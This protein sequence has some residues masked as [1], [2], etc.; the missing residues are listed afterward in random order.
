[1]R[2]LLTAALLVLGAA[3]DGPTNATQPKGPS[4]YREVRPFLARYCVWCHN[5]EKTEG[6]LDLTDYESL[7]LGGNSG[8]VIVPGRP[9]A[10]LL[11]LLVEK[12]RK[13]HMPPPE[14][15][16]PSAEE[17][18]LLRRWI[19]AGAV[20]DTDQ[21]RATLVLPTIRP[22]RS[23][24]PAIVDSDLV[25]DGSLLA[26]AVGRYVVLLKPAGQQLW[27]RVGPLPD[28]VTAVAL[29]SD[30]RWLAAAFGMPTVAAKVAIYRLPTHPLYEPLRPARILEAH[31]DTVYDLAFHPRRPEVLASAS[32]DKLVR[33][34][35]VAVGKKLA[36]LKDHSD[37]VYGLAWSPD[38]AYL[39]TAAA[40]RTVKIWH[41]ASR[42]RLYSLTES[43]DWLYT[44]AWHPK[45][46][47]V[48]AAGVDRSIRIWEVSEAGGR[49][50]R[51]TFA[52][53]GPVVQLR[54][55]ADGSRLVSIAEDGTLKWWQA[56]TLTEERTLSGLEDQPH[57]LAIDPVNGTVFVGLFNGLLKVVPAR[58]ATGV[59]ALPAARWLTG[60]LPKP[61]APQITAVEPAVAAAGATVRVTVKGKQLRWIERAE[62]QGIAAA[63]LKLTER[64][65]G[66]LVLSVKLPSDVRGGVYRL[67]LKGRGGQAATDLLVVEYPLVAEVEPNNRRAAAQRVPAGRS[68]R[69]R[70]EAAGAIDF[71]A[72]ELAAGDEIGVVIRNEPGARQLEPIV[73]VHDPD[74]R[75]VASSYDGLAGW[76][77]ERAGRYTVEVR[78]AQFRGAGNAWYVITMGK[79]P[80]VTEV[81]P[82]GIPADG[83]SRTVVVRGVNLGMPE[84]RVQIAAAAEEVGKWRTLRLD[85]SPL[86]PVRVFLGRFPAVVEER[87]ST[88]EPAGWLRLKQIPGTVDGRI[89][90][91]GDVDYVAFQARAGEQL[92]VELRAADLGSRLDSF[93]EVLD[94]DLRP[95]ERAV[96][97]CEAQTYT[98]LNVRDARQTGFRIEA[99]AELATND[100]LYADGEVVRIKR[101]PRNP[102]DDVLFFS[103]GGRRLTYFDTTPSYK[104]VGTVVY[105]VS[106]HPPGTK[107][108]PNGMPQ[109]RLYYRNDDAAPRYERDSRV[110]FTAPADGTYVVAIRDARGAGGVGYGYRLTVRPPEPGFRISVSPRSPSVWQGGAVPIRISC[111]R[112]D[113]FAGPVTVTFERVPKGCVL[114][115][116]VVEAETFD[117]SVPLYAG[118]ELKPGP[119]GSGD[120][121]VVARAVID[122]KAVTQRLS[123]GQIRVQPPGDIVTS[124]D[125]QELLLAPGATAR[126]KVSIR[127]RGGFKGRVPIELVGLPHGVRVLDVGLNGILITEREQERWIRVYAEPWVGEQ[128]RWFGVYARREGANTLHGAAP[129]KLRI[130]RGQLAKQ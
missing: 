123:L 122:G 102:D 73:L 8:D 69:G 39:A 23:V 119:Q 125:R 43:T 57:T 7:S 45:R 81:F 46:N 105:K 34:W 71:Y 83:K 97:R 112:L 6:G 93:I 52:H 85:P 109:F 59:S 116:T 74:G 104:P 50:L 22:R 67:V 101:L 61:P 42:K 75:V 44:V 92:V 13:P 55:S 1:M 127:R 14:A 15:R 53:E 120:V 12:K 115:G 114:P 90:R 40:D 54:F 76:R 70:L 27:G 11:V 48:A 72:I 84:R 10:S 36:D 3:Q 107:L 32:Y 58:G 129:V 25:P 103:F 98:T 18:Q 126:L 20:D 91:P 21:A 82:L 100:Y 128:E 63:V 62:L 88:Q 16:Q 68:V 86:N 9:D 56:A 121:Q 79:L 29:S 2:A 26:L 19:A 51:S 89:D 31:V 87:D 118:A 5:A 96:L 111:E 110:Y 24:P 94:Q 35:D 4:Y 65:A 77:A 17:I 30:G 64:G 117:A 38:G 66:E 130:R 113:Q 108:T 99:W 41:V 95:I 106:V 124:V 78:D 33:L 80:V 47:W 49:L 28:R 37:A 60:P